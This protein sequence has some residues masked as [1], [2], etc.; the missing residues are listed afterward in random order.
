MV[1]F[2]TVGKSHICPKWNI[3]VTITGKYY[4]FDNSNPYIAKYVTCKC[5]ILENI[6]L[7]IA[8]RNKEYMLYHFCNME[9]ECLGNI[10]FSPQIDVRKDGYSQ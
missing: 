1:S 5:P 3:S 7:P 4:F 8:E 6:K 9:Q 2:T 10:P